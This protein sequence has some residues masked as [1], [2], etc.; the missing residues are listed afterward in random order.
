MTFDHARRDSVRDNT[1]RR[2]AATGTRRAAAITLHAALLLMALLPFAT[3]SVHAQV[4]NGAGYATNGNYAGSILWLD[5][6][7]YDDAQ[8][9]SGQAFSFDLPN[10]NRLSMTVT[11]TGSANVVNARPVPTWFGAAF[12]NG[13]YDGIPGNPVLYGAGII[14]YAV[15]LS[16]LVAVDAAGNPRQLEM[17]VADGESTGLHE[18]EWMEF[19]TNGSGWQLVELL[20]QPG[21][22]G[23]PPTPVLTGLGSA[24][25]RWQGAQDVNYGSV[26]LHSVQPT[27][28]SV[29]AGTNSGAEGFLVG[30]VLPRVELR[31]Q[32]PDGLFDPA[33]SVTLATAYASPALPLA[34]TVTSGPGNASNG[35]VSVWPNSAVTIGETGSLA[36][37]T[38]SIQCNNANPITDPVTPLPAGAGTQFQLTPQFGDD[39]VC[40]LINARGA[41]PANV[42]LGK[43]LTSE[44]GS[45]PGVAEPGE[46]LTYTIHLVNSGGSDAVGYAVSDHLDPNLVFLSASNGGS[47]SAGFVNWS[48]LTVPAGGSLDLTVTASVRSPLPVGTL[49][50]ANLAYPTGTTPPACPPAGPQ[51]VVTP[52]AAQPN[53]AKSVSDA[54]G[55]GLAEAG[56]LLTY[57]IVVGNTGGTAITGYSLTDVLD[58]NTTF[59]SASHGG[60]HA[61]GVVSWTGLNVPVNGSLVLTVVAQVVDPIPADVIRIANLVHVTGETPP[62]CSD[63]PTPATCAII[64]VRVLPRIA[65]SKSVD[66]SGIAGGSVVYTVSVRNVGTIDAAG[67]TIGDLVP[68]GIDS[69]SWTCTAMAGAVCPAAAG[70]GPVNATV[71]VFPPASSLVYAIT[72]SIAEDAT[73]RIFNTATA[74][75]P[76]GGLCGP[77]DSAPP[78]SATVDFP[79]ATPYQPRLPVPVD[80]P[81]AELLMVLGLLGIGGLAARRSRH[82]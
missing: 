77:D 59:V 12:G 76:D 81:I 50:V 55:N 54:S 37:Y 27:T 47:Y 34:S 3:P 30:V 8:A 73:Q 67:T 60:S 25:A 2:A 39:I 80:S 44:S 52:T 22:G 24:T 28:I 57:S 26:L 36:N 43:T 70:S 49:Q 9:A 66:T 63:K 13:A 78:C 62:D 68:A 29:S 16:N 10:G 72:A 14:Q 51:C 33:D 69:F 53:L 45:Q 6:S 79:P 46:T 82:R 20:S 75:P 11:R 42:S 1:F 19:A 56:E 5:F 40:T 17:V 4:G 41:L 15:T 31:K 7:G 18:L 38:S 35:V 58:P 61:A 71:T 74:I 32:F 23:A 65:I 48:G 21:S 64:P